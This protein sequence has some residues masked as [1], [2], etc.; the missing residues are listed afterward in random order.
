[1]FGSIPQSQSTSQNFSLKLPPKSN[2]Y[3]D[4][5]NHTISMTTRA[6]TKSLIQKKKT[7]KLPE[8]LTTRASNGV[9]DGVLIRKSE[10]IKKS[11]TL[12][13][14]KT[15]K[16]VKKFVIGCHELT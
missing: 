2:R 12:I 1:M 10:A 3:L 16:K 6:S 5:S 13:K 4:K 15:K 14:G 7:S 11:K 8:M 9:L